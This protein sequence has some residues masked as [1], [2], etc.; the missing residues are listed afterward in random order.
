MSRWIWGFCAALVST[1]ALVPSSAS[2]W[3]E[4]LPQLS[5]EQSRQV[6]LLLDSCECNQEVYAKFHLEGMSTSGR[7]IAFQFL[8]PAG[9]TC[10]MSLGESSTGGT[11]REA[12]GGIG[13]W[14]GCDSA[15]DAPTS[16]G[17]YTAVMNRLR[18]PEGLEMVLGGPA[19][20]VEQPPALETE[21][22]SSWL[23]RMQWLWIS[24]VG[25]LGVIWV[26]AGAKQG[27]RALLLETLA[28]T[29]VLTVVRL[30]H[31]LYSWA[32]TTSSDGPW[33]TLKPGVLER[34]GSGPGS[35]GEWGLGWTALQVQ[36]PMLLALIWMAEWMRRQAGVSSAWWFPLI[37]G[38]GIPMNLVWGTAG[39][40]LGAGLSMLALLS[41]W[42]SWGQRK[43]GPKRWQRWLVQA[44]MVAGVA[45]VA[46]MAAAALMMAWGG[47]DPGISGGVPQSA[48]TFFDVLQEGSCLF[49]TAPLVAMGLWSLAW[50][51]DWKGATAAVIAVSGLAAAWGPGEPSWP[52]LVAL[53]LPTAVALAAVG[54]KWACDTAMPTR[55]RTAL[56]LAALAVM[57]HHGA[58]HLWGRLAI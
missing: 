4:R 52:G 15:V 40:G 46:G 3:P 29:A 2:A 24:L 53:A 50:R 43:A 41:A 13:V 20:E 16:D 23:W 32:S 31:P 22:L 39:W 21:S 17:L 9:H 34:L 28:G 44:L 33:A 12:L 14:W 48:V 35:G 42:T 19:I 25:L 51:G 47:G 11:Q 27:W 1:V 7:H 55:I 36:G 45:G 30:G 18:A 26:A 54:L 58:F 8:G 6:Y 5:P 49:V 38:L 10:T 56:F 57:L 37:I